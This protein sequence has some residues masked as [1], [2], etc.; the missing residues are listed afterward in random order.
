MST[1]SH[2]GTAATPDGRR[3]QHCDS[4]VTADFVRVFGVDGSA[5]RCL[6]CA[7]LA[8]LRAGA[9]AGL[10]SAEHGMVR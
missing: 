1:E 2:G 4:H 8:E 3:C 10:D 5:Q 6:D 9:A 7:T